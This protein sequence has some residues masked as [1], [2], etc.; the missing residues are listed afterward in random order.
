VSGA[1]DPRALAFLDD[2][3]QRERLAT[4]R[5]AHPHVLIGGGEFGT[6]QALIP[7]E[8]GEMIVVRYAL[9]ELLDKLE[10]LSA[11]VR[12]ETP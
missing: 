8:T 1:A 6:W 9:R 11:P 7:E 2:A 5:A 3:G 4:F 10:E 12:R